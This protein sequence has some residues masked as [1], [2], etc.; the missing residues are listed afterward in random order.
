MCSDDGTHITGDDFF[1]VVFFTEH[2]FQGSGI[3]RAVTV[4]DEYRIEIRAGFG[5]LLDQ[6]LRRYP[7]G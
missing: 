5:K 2:G 3:L 4:A 7:R 1:D 6:M